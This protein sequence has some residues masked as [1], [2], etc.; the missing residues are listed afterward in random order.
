MVGIYAELTGTSLLLSNIAAYGAKAE[1]A[2][3]HICKQLAEDLRDKMIEFARESKYTGYLIRG[4]QENGVH[5]VGPSVY[6]VGPYGVPYAE[7]VEYGSRP[8]GAPIEA[9]TPWAEDHGLEPGVLWGIIK[10]KGT[11]AEPFIIPAIMAMRSEMTV[12]ELAKIG[13][14]WALL[15]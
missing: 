12:A 9:I 7:Y 4:L 11:Q 8:H 2:E 1:V 10:K 6:E 3:D 14:L 5:H 13:A 15:G